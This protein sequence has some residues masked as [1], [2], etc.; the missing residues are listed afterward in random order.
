MNW[1]TRWHEEFYGETISVPLMLAS[2]S[3]LLYI[4]FLGDRDPIMIAIF[5][6]QFFRS[7]IALSSE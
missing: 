7:G 4:L 6:L 1:L 3:R 5:G 2:C